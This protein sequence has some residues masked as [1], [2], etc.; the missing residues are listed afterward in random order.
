MGCFDDIIAIGGCEEATP[1]SGVYLRDAG[2]SIDDLGYMFGV[3]YSDGQ[4]L[5]TDKIRVATNLVVNEL[6]A[7]FA[8]KYI[9]NGILDNQRVGYFLE[10]KPVKTGV[11][12]LQGID[13]DIKNTNSYISIYIDKIQMHVNYTGNITVNIYDAIQNKVLDTFVVATTAGVITDKIINKT[14]QSDKKRLHLVI[15]YNANGIDSY[16]TSLTSSGGCSSCQLGSYIPLNQYVYA[17]PV[18]VSSSTVI[19]ENIFGLSHTSGLSVLYSIKCNHE[20][21]LCRYK[22]EIAWPIAYKACAEIIQYAIYQS[23]RA[24]QKKFNEDQLKERWNLYNS[25]YTKYMKN[26]TSN[27]VIPNDPKCF[28]C[29]DLTRTRIT[30]P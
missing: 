16:E 23:S 27:I 28:A 17:K 29:K 20:E 2:V 5:A 24:N 7:N 13:L 26:I 11:N 1:S 3:E 9:T 21:W 12:Q 25:N 10:N 6:S 22:N 18:Y 19:D 15:A 30:L 8:S 4:A 14:Y